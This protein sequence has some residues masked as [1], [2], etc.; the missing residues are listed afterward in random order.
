MEWARLRYHYGH[1]VCNHKVAWVG[2]SSEGTKV[3]TNLVERY[4]GIIKS[5]GTGLALWTG[6]VDAGK[7]PR[8]KLDERWLECGCG[9]LHAAPLC[10]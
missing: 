5:L 9:G 7:E 4:N 2:V 6:G 1:E 8:G 3:T 10:L